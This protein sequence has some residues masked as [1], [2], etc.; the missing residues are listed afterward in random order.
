LIAEELNVHR[1]EVHADE[2]GLVDL[3]AKPNFKV[4]GPRFGKEMGAVAAQVASLTHEDIAAA[5][6]GATVTAGS[7]ALTA[8]DLVVTRSPRDGTVVATEGSLSVALDVS[9][10]EDLRIEGVAREIVNRTQTARR[11]AGFEVVDRIALTW[12]SDDPD[13]VQA[14]ARHSDLIA[15]EVLAETIV[16]DDAAKG[17]AV[18]LLGANLVLGVQTV[19]SA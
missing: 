4:L 17:D 16:R 11:D 1:V 12:S 15:G 7:Y 2:A 8:E 6:D 5:L 13:V 3:Q 14:F 19:T 18:D 10:D 9:I